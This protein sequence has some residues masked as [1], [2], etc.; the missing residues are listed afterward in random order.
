MAKETKVAAPA[1]DGP[2]K[3]K[4]AP[5]KPMT[6]NWED[7]KKGSASPTTL[8]EN[9][10]VA[11]VAKNLMKLGEKNSYAGT[12]YAGKQR[13]AKNPI[14]KLRNPL[15]TKTNEIFRPQG[16]LDKKVEGYDKVKDA[17]RSCKADVFNGTWSPAAKAALE[18]LYGWKLAGGGSGGGVRG[19]IAMDLAKL[20]F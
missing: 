16:K 2:K 6:P 11:L 5:A 8:V 7:Y 3:A 14:K 15:G 4:N 9:Q 10:L 12:A 17:M 19:P 1:G 13:D 18:V 20:T